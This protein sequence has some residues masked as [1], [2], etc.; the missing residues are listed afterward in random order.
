MTKL[1]LAIILGLVTAF[2]SGTNNFLSKIAV[3]TVADPI[4]FTFLKNAITVLLLLSA[5]LIT[6]RWR[7]IKLLRK[8][9]IIQLLFIGILGGGVP[10][11][12]FFTGLSLIPV[13]QAAFI[14][15]TLFLWVA[16]LA[17][18]F[19]KE[20]ISWL[21]LGA[22][23]LLLI[24]N[25]G[26][27]GIPRF[28]GHIGEFMVLG[29][30]LLWAIENII[31]KKVLNS[32]SSLLV[33]STRM[34]IGSIVISLVLIAQHKTSVILTLSPAQWSW[35]VLTGL[36]LTGYV[37]TWYTALKYA[38]AVLVASLLVPATLVTNLLTAIFITH[39]FPFLQLLST[40]LISLGTILIISRAGNL[41]AHHRPQPDYSPHP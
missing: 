18:P 8:P 27:F 36:L 35:T 22:L 13:A 16:L 32:C 26:L 23:C 25:L 12:L 1:K 11:I 24:G 6:S 15:K 31:S 40:A 3:T 34:L 19:L 28:T 41:P 17:V 20:K 9:Q 7:E 33:A 5:I 37:V 14:H 30:T 29:A 21:Q 10:F 38:P 4:V 2:I 39:T